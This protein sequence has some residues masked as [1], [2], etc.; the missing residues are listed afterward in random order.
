[1]TQTFEPI[2]TVAGVIY[3]R[4]AIFLDDVHF[5]YQKNII[6]LRGEL[7]SPLCSIYKDNEDSFISYSLTFSGVL[8]F[9]MTEL[10]FKDYGSSSF[11]RVVNSEW[12]D[13]MRRKD[14]SAKVKPNHEHYLVF[15]YDDVFDVVCENYELKIS[16]MREKQKRA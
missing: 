6:E 10:D 7:N 5:D 4:D 2:E 8:A 12:L 16:E 15:T 14:H 11:D 3:G 1:M 13:E 9:A